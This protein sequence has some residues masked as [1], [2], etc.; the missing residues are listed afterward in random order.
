MTPE[1]QKHLFEPFFTTK[2][3]G[4]GTGLGLAAVYGAIH[5]HRGAITVYSELG[6]GTTFKLY[7]PM[8]DDGARTEHV[9]SPSWPAP[10]EGIRILL[11]DDEE[12]IRTMAT[13]V[14]QEM[15]HRVVTCNDGEDA[16]ALYRGA[17]REFDLVILDMVMPRVGGRDAFLAM[18]Q[19]N[20]GIRAVLS[21]GYS[22]TG[23]AQ[24]ILDEGIQGF[25]QKPFR[26]ADLLQVIVTVC[27][28]R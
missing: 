20:P 28:S 15:G 16:I 19:I 26:V 10:G 11:V 27:S 12:V 1:T 23:E 21:S 7:L 8:V 6:H 4:K 9:P 18:R 25:I 3:P 22:L 5:N 2:S 24:R 14:L 17:W 13:A